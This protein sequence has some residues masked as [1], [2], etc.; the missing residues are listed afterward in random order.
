MYIDANL[1]CI[2]KKNKKIYTA[3]KKKILEY[4]EMQNK[5]YL[6]FRLVQTK[7]GQKTIEVCNKENNIVR[8]N[9]VYNPKKEAIRWGKKFD[10]ID[11]ITSLIMYGYGNGI[12]FDELEKRLDKSAYVFFYEPDIELFIFCLNMFDMKYILS[13]KRVFLYI[14]GINDENFYMD[15]CS[16]INW[17]MLPSQ[18]VCCH[19]M[20]DKLYQI[21]YNKFKAIIDEYKYALKLSE[22]T[23]LHCAKKFTVNTIRNLCF[24][25]NSNYIGE[26][27]GKIDKKIPII[28][29]SAGPSLDKNVQK[30]KKAKGKAFILATDS[31][32]KILVEFKIGFD[33]IVT[34]DGNKYIEKFES[35]F[36]KNIPIFTIPD[37]K[38]DLLEQSSGRKIWITGQG[39]Y[40]SLYKKY[41]YDFPRYS[42]GGSVAT[43]AFS[44]A[45]ILG[46]KNI[47]LVGQDLAYDGNRTHSGN[48]FLGCVED[49]EEKSIYVDGVYEKKVRTKYDWFRYLQWFENA[50]NQLDSDICVVDATEGGAKIKGTEIMTLSDAIDKYCIYN[51][52][53]QKFIKEIPAT[54]SNKYYKKICNDIYNILGE[55]DIIYNKCLDSKRVADKLLY[56][57]KN[58]RVISEEIDNNIA[59]IK[60]SQDLIQKQKIYILLD[61]YISSDVF[62]RIK[63]AT[64]TYRSQNEKMYE[65]IKSIDVLFTA[66]I[67]AI[68]EL[69]P[70]VDK[71]LKKI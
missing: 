4:D 32:V 35:E 13:D 60:S 69:R 37:A 38:T 65:D 28:I 48:L 36:C 47:I 39:Y 27:I 43:A 61:E 46:T 34:I 51:F 14:D 22:N 59:I 29:V 7:N 55:F 5:D 10:N 33:A 30:L 8:L 42:A 62:E 21:S 12:F 54:F 45:K 71:V 31:A 57:I 67:K 66:L 52:D 19:P 16:K 25:K 9:S 70:V 50:I 20:Y 49:N 44:I 53:F 3:I 64:K 56:M 24:I 58:G 41:G 18:V 6:K 68:D 23:S 40:T 63:V 11:R 15:L 17:T 26:F 2:K 1:E